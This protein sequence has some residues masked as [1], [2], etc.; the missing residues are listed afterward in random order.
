MEPHEALV[1]DVDG[2]VSPVSGS[3]AWGGDV[4]GYG[5]NRG[6][7]RVPVSPRLNAALG[8]LADRSEVTASG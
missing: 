6:V 3:T 5:R 8:D 2:V 7:G 4:D 1:V